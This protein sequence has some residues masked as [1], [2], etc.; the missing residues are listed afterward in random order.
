MTEWQRTPVK[1]KETLIN[2]HNFFCTIRIVRAVTE[3]VAET[4]QAGLGRTEQPKSEPQANQKA[5]SERQAVYSRYFNVM[6]FDN[7][8]RIN[9]FTK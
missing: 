9:C 5:F 3:T 8:I 1:Q 6:L 7:L 4:N 2:K